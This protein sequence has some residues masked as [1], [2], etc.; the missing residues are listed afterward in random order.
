MKRSVFFRLFMPYFL[1]SLFSLGLVLI[2]SHILAFDQFVQAEYK[3]LR[4]WEQYII[5]QASQ[6]KD[7]VQGLRRTF[8]NQSLQTLGITLDVLEKR[9]QDYYSWYQEKIVTN[10]I[11]KNINTTLVLQGFP[12]ESYNIFHSEKQIQFVYGTSIRLSNGKPLI[13]YITR[14]LD[15]EYRDFNLSYRRLVVFSLI[16][17]LIVTALLIFFSIRMVNPLK[18]LVN[19]AREVTSGNLDARVYLNSSDEHMELADSFNQISEKNKSLFKQLSTEKEELQAIISSL[20]ESLWLIDKDEKIVFSNDTFRKWLGRED[21]EGRHYWE[22]IRDQG[23]DKLISEVQNTHK[24]LQ[25]EITLLAKDVVFSGQYVASSNRVLVV[26][27]DISEFRKAQLVKKDLISSVSHELKTPLTSIKGFVETLRLNDPSPEDDHY[28]QI[29]ER[30]TNR[31]SRIVQD[32]LLLS[33]LEEGG[34]LP[35]TE[36]VDLKS[37]MER[38][39]QLFQQK[40]EEKDLYLDVELG[41]NLIVHS[42]PYKL[43]QV[44]INLIDNACKY[45][46]KGGLSI[47]GVREKKFVSIQLKDTGIGIPA[48][49]QGRIFERFYVVDKSRSRRQ[50][51]T[52][53]GLSI[54]RHIMELLQGDIQFSS[55]LHE[56]TTF[57]IHI[58]FELI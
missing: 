34:R 1:L 2:Y 7:I 52:G 4:N 13:L 27:N 54:V 15:G 10:N 22:L 39:V 36:K 17:F 16:V 51:G 5:H 55:V 57:T 37:L 20:Q 12:Q 38:M 35:E 53:L 32:L 25:Q 23:L 58:P 43:E 47:L 29:I 50:G 28:L 41:D 21:V 11:Q 6:D 26:L 30:N 19:V 56:G 31:L 24:P 14:I 33:H 44:F 3:S 46:E 8:S 48:H 40:F 9:G 42:D 18:D 45:T 49:Q